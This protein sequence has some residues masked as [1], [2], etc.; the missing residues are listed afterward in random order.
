VLPTTRQAAKILA[1]FFDEAPARV[2]NTNSADH[3]KVMR[4]ALT[5]PDSNEVVPRP[6][7]R[8][9]TWAR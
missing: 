4:L 7:S 6:G 5:D 2:A 3:G 1:V 8:R 9:T